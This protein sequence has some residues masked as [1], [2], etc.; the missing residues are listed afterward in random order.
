MKFTDLPLLSIGNTIQLAG[1][2]YQSDS[3]SYLIMLP[4][5]KDQ[6]PYV[7]LDDMSPEDWKDLICQSDLCETEVSFG[8]K[9]A[10]LRKCER[11]VDAKVSWDCF[12]RDLFKCQYCFRDDLPLTVDHI[13][14]WEE[15]GP[16]TMD[17]LLSVCKPCNRKRGNTPYAEWIASNAYQKVSQNLSQY[18]K[19]RNEIVV[20]TL[21]TIKKVD[22]IRS[23]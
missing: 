5:E 2:V 9:K 3:H 14:V 8:E 12:R 4:G 23:R 17:N 7:P 16:T 6:F 18:A 13:V 22:H 15:G 19:M 11:L 20:H 10:I 1:A 21:G